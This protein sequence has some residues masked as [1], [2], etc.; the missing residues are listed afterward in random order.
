[1]ADGLNIKVNAKLDVG[2]TTKQI[3]TQLS[4]VAKNIQPIQLNAKIDTDSIKQQTQQIQ[5]QINSAV[6][7]TSSNTKPISLDNVFKFDTH[8]MTKLMEQLTVYK[9]EL[10]KLS[11]ISPAKLST[12]TNS[13]GNI[14]S[15]K[16]TYFN[17]RLKSSVTEV[18]ELDKASKE[19]NSSVNRLA[20]TGTTYST[21]AYNAA[22]QTEKFSQQLQAF[23]TTVNSFGDKNVGALLDSNSLGTQYQKLLTGLDSVKDNNGLNAVK[24]QFKDLQAQTISYIQDQRTLKTEVN[25]T[26]NSQIKDFEI[27]TKSE[28]QRQAEIQKT[29][30]KIE[31]LTA[32]YN[33]FQAQLSKNNKGISLDSLNQENVS[34]LQGALN[35]NNIQQTTHFLRLLKTEYSEL[36]E[37]MDKPFSS[38][39]LE[40]FESRAQKLSQ[41]IEIIKSKFSN[42]NLGGMSGFS[43][44]VSQVSQNVSQLKTNLDNFNKAQVGQEKVQAFNT[45]NSSVK[46]TKKQ[47][48]DLFKAQQALANVDITSNKFESYLKENSRVADKFSTKVNAI[49]TSLKS[50]GN[51]TDT[52][53]LTTGLQNVNKQFSNLKTS[54]EKAGIEGRTALQ[55]IGH[56]LKKMF[57]WT[58]GGTA[59]FGTINE[60]KQM[61]S[62]VSDLNKAMTNIQMAS[63][64]SSDEVGKMM[65]TYAQMGQTLGATTT[66]VATSADSFLRQGKSVK[67]TNDLIKDSMVLSKIGEVD[68]AAATDYLTSAM[69]G[70]NVATKD[71][72][73][74]VDKLSAVDMQSAISAGGL[75][76]GM[77]KTANMAN[78][79]GRIFAR[80]YSNIWVA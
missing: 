4:E 14:D 69:K 26:T 23:K 61:I 40:K 73:S 27:L 29:S 16:F 48:N 2:S 42:I 9:N 39:A 28:Q 80:P 57:Y 68:S 19:A 55:E 31:E 35:S 64:A 72:I 41:D 3:Q 60:I 30:N 79:A 21:N 54:A 51:E 8:N 34:G 43:G 36:N 38:N 71:A 77:S 33:K 12:H 50:L 1:M 22:Q 6:S 74:I 10:S 47:V 15:A 67:D 59:I 70:Y 25:N 18:Y 7:N 17:D 75:A 11:D 63:G 32:D 20:L 58:V 66:E 53:K 52:T 13:L 62:N 44:K 78:S 65:N 24:N 76:E 49:R 37:A 56:D 46:E 5:S 45:L